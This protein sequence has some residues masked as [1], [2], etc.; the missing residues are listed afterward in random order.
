VPIMIEYIQKQ[1]LL[2]KQTPKDLAN[3][4]S[5]LSVN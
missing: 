3:D 1:L 4:G 5:D 2:M